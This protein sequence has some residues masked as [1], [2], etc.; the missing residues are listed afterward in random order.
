M[1]TLSSS[2]FSCW[3]FSWIGTWYKLYW[4]CSQIQISSDSSWNEME[5]VWSYD[6]NLFVAR[7]LIQVWNARSNFTQTLI[8]KGGVSW[9]NKDWLTLA[10]SQNVFPCFLEWLASFQKWK[11]L[12]L[13]HSF[14][15]KIKYF[16]QKIA[17]LR[18]SLIL[19]RF[20]KMNWIPLSFCTVPANKLYNRD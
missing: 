2:K 6:K 5:C 14:W 4:F 15:D 9:K 10:M 20:K 3:S 19:T 11:F 1:R 8:D 18:R 12:T 16:W 13:E 7:K 17:C